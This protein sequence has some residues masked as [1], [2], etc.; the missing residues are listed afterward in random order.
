MAKPPK[1]TAAKKAAPKK[2]AA[3]KAVNEGA[4]AS[5]KVE[6]FLDGGQAPAGKPKAAKMVDKSVEEQLEEL[7]PGLGHNLKE[8][9]TYDE[10]RGFIDELANM[11][12]EVTSAVGELR[13]RLKQILEDR[14]WNKTAV[15]D[16]RKLSRMPE[17]KRADYLRTMLPLQQLM[18]HHAW[19]PELNDILSDLEEMEDPEQKL[20]DPEGDPDFD[21][22]DT[23]AEQGKAPEPAE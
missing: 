13:A 20:D 23:D 21:D 9:T 14:S 22:V 16:I 2:K 1:K 8:T 4:R 10:L 12:M 19:G 3:A 18:L 15:A 6:E 5:K 7:Y 17:T 11:Q